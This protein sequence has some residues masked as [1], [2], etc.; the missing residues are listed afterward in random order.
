MA[1]TADQLITGRL[2]AATRGQGPAA[3]ST[4]FYQGTLCFSDSS[5]NVASV[6]ASG[7]NTILGVVTKRVDNSAG[8]AGDVDVEYYDNG[9][10]ELVGSGFAA[11]DV[12]AKVYASDNYTITKTSTSNTL[13][14]TITRFIS[15]TVVEVMIDPQAA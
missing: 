2:E 14:G 5:G 4:T 13:V 3:A 12:G 8:S 6:T 7:A 9:K 10:F 15:S 1:V 11:A